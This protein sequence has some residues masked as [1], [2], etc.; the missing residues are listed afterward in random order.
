[1]KKKLYGY[2][3]HY[4]G[5]FICCIDLE[6][7]V[8]CCWCCFLSSHI[9]NLHC[10]VALAHKHTNIRTHI[11]T[12]CSPFIH[13]YHSLFTF[14]KQKAMH[15]AECT[16]TRNK[17]EV[18]SILFIERYRFIAY[19]SYIYLFILCM[20]LSCLLLLLLLMLVLYKVN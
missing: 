11:C 9:G 10:I 3:W 2:R 4:F 8:D 16:Q 19:R 6:D 17:R 7:F 15:S 20:S 13:I 5:H 12:L 1:M 18:I 14:S